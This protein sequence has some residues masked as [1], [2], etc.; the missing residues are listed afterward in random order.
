MCKTYKVHWTPEERTIIVGKAA[1]LIC[2]DSGL[3]HLD[4]LRAGIDLLPADRR[5]KVIAMSQV[6]WFPK[7]VR[8]EMAR[9]ATQDKLFYNTA[10]HV[11]ETLTRLCDDHVVCR[12]FNRDVQARVDRNHSLLQSVDELKA[13]VK[14]NTAL[15]Q[16][17]LCRIGAVLPT[18]G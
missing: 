5:R 15:I 18:D 16:A 1:D 10:N 11:L 14:Q 17:V 6:P 9:R 3:G 8:E 2:E 7:L 12:E 4:L 13:A